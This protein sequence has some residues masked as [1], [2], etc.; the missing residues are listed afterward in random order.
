MADLPGRIQ[1]TVVSRERRIV[2]A[3]VDEVILPATD[4][5]IGVLPGHTPLLAT[6]KIGVLRYRTGT[7][8]E[9]LVISWGFAEVL[10]DRVIVLAEKGVLPGEIDA[11]TAE[12]ERRRAEREIMDL[13]SHDPEFALVEARLEE[14]VAMISV[15]REH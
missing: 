6:L 14:S 3:Q 5:E 10:P 11:A 4:G 15:H 9:R 13:S 7:K 8:V 1:L 2:D 12:E